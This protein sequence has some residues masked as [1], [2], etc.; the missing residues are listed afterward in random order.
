MIASLLQTVSAN[1]TPNSP[2]MQN[3]DLLAFAGFPP[4]H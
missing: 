4:A 3:E 2:R 1:Q